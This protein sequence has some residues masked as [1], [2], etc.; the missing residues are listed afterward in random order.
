M[1]KLH[2]VTGF[3]DSYFSAN[4]PVRITSV[5]HP[6]EKLGEAAAE[7]LLEMLKDNNYLD[8]PVQKIIVPELIIKESCI[9]R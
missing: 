1:T 8:N 7:L 5:S 3:D 9:K 2:S 4:C 6:K